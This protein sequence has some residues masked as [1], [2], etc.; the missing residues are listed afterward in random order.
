MAAALGCSVSAPVI[1][2]V[3]SGLGIGGAEASLVQIATALQARGLPQHVVCAGTLDDHAEEL[4]SCGVEVTVLGV[5]SA[6][7]L[8]GGVIRIARMIRRLDPGVVQGWMYHG[9]TLAAIAHRL[10]HRSTQRRLYW[11]L[12]ASNV[13]AA[14]Y[15][16]VVRLGAML[17]RW[18]DLMIANSQAGAKFH[19]DHGFRPRRMAVI[20]NGIDTQKFRPNAQARAALR[21][22]LGIPTDAVVAI[23]AARVDPMKD[24]PAMLAAMAAVPHVQGLLVGA[25]T[26]ALRVPEN[27]RAIGLRR[28]LACLY[29]TA[30]I[31]V[32]SSAFGEGFSNVV[33]EG[34]SVGL[35]PVATDV[36]DAREIIGDAGYVVAPGDVA[37]LAG[38]LAAAASGPAADRL[39]RGLKARAH[40]VGQFP[41]SMTIEAYARLYDSGC[42]ALPQSAIASNSAP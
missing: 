36:G 19:I 34:M 27:V 2:H 40:I 15:G 42:A 11:N 10:A 31:V 38:A 9:N 35:I 16:R 25:G 37:S 32:S 8:P 5:N 17:S 13:D 22:Q 6:V 28:D 1:L 26:E 4:R 3:I 33:A 14:R 39:A 30:D 21:D 7:R 29:A 20:G 23:H 18:P 41:L 24:H 12:R